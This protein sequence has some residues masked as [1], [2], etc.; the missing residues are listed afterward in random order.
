MALKDT[1]VEIKEKEDGT[2]EVKGDA[3][4][5]SP[6]N[7]FDTF[8]SLSI[9]EA[10]VNDGESIV[11]LQEFADRP[12]GEMTDDY[13]LIVIDYPHVVEIAAKGLLDNFDKPQYMHNLTNL[14]N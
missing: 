7:R 9:V 1:F 5:K 11:S 12:I 10:A 3:M 6:P 8:P 4:L 13:D 2:K 14:L